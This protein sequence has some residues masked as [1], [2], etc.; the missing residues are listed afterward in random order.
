MRRIPAPL[1]PLLFLL[2]GC[3][4]AGAGSGAPHAAADCGRGDP[5]GNTRLAMIRK[6]LD[7][8]HP[9]A[10]LAH[11]DATAMRGP[12][13]ELLRADILRRLGRIDEAR[14]LYQGLLAGCM[15]GAGHHGLGLLAGQQGMLAESLDH[16]RR[17]RT[18][19]PV[20]AR[21]RSDLGYALL[22]AGEVDA[23]RTEFLTAQDV[24]PDDR[25]AGLNLALLYFRQGDDA[26]AESVARR[27]RASEDEL[28]KLREE[29]ARLAAQRGDGK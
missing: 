6:L 7:N 20:D 28:A 8:G 25:K 23:A 13:A 11:L 29:A 21:V 15:A 5:G 9:Y 14:S 26:R 2:G 4:A 18:M 12:L 16:L 1:L 27:Y 24:D 10:A 22:L 17:A 3:A 19:L